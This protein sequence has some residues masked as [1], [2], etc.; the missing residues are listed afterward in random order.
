MCTA[1]HPRPVGRLQSAIGHPGYVALSYLY[2]LGSE[3][4]IVLNRVLGA[5]DSGG[6]GKCIVQ[7]PA[8]FEFH[9]ENP[10]EINIEIWHPHPRAWRR[11]S[12]GMVTPSS[13]SLPGSVHGPR[14]LNR[15]PGG[16]AGA[17]GCQRRWI[18]RDLRRRHLSV[19]L[20]RQLLASVVAYPTLLRALLDG[21]GSRFV[22]LACGYGYLLV[23]FSRFTLPQIETETVRRKFPPRIGP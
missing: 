2:V 13:S 6:G 21:L 5:R 14:S 22:Y 17:C 4:D 10:S 3:R 23:T 16:G 9:P 7:I 15:R 8:A 1:W 12:T 18:A 19:H 20:A 11:F